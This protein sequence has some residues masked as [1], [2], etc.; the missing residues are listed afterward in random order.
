MTTDYTSRFAI[1]PAAASAMG[2][3]ELRHNFHLAGLFVADRINLTYTHYDRMIVGGAMPVNG[4]LKL[5]AIKP[6]G[7]KSFLERRE[8]VA[9]NIG[10]PG[11]VQ[12][13]SQSYD[14]GARDMIYVG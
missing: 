10:G 8:L 6:T 4:A 12:V 14:L 13:G 5:E 1:D 2:T 9:V 3:D 11:K 7:T